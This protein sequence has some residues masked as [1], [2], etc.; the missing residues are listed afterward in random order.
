MPRNC[1]LDLGF[2]LGAKTCCALY[3]GCIQQ[4]SKAS[5]RPFAECSQVTD[6]AAFPIQSVENKAPTHGSNI[7]QILVLFFSICQVHR[8]DM[9]ILYPCSTKMPA[10]TLIP[11]S[12]PHAFVRILNHITSTHYSFTC[13]SYSNMTF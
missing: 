11:I 1:D 13:L 9:F 6:L 2:A 10:F 12:F 3:M 8:C 5:T 7:G 4:R